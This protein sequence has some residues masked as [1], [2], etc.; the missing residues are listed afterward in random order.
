M[1]KSVRVLVFLAMWL[2]C[3]AVQAA[4]TYYCVAT[5][6]SDAVANP[7]TSWESP[8]LT[9]SNALA[10]SVAADVILVSNG[11]Y[12]LAQQI[13]VNKGVTI[14]GVNGPE[15]VV[16]DGNQ[17]TRCFYVTAVALLANMTLANG[18]TNGNGGG[19][20]LDNAGACVTNC[21]IRDNLTTNSGSATA[22]GGGVFISA[23][24]GILSNCFI[25]G[26]QATH[27]YYG[28]KNNGGGV[29]MLNGQVT[30][31]LIASNAVRNWDSAG[32]SQGGGI[33][34]FSGMASGCTISNNYS[35]NSG[36]GSYGSLSNCIIAENSCY[37][38]GGGS[39]LGSSPLGQRLVYCTIISNR[40]GY[41]GYGGGVYIDSAAGLLNCVVQGNRAY[42]VAGISA[43]SVTGIWNT[44]ICQN[45]ST[46][47]WG[48][49]SG[50]NIG[51]GSVGRPT[52]L[53]NCTIVS[54]YPGHGVCFNDASR[55]QNIT[56]CI[57]AYN[58]NTG[59][60]DIKFFGTTYTTNVFY[61][62]CCPT[63]VLPANQG[64]ITNAPMFKDFV[65]GNYRLATGSPCINAGANLAGMADTVD[66]DGHL[67]IDKFSGRIDIGAYEYL[68]HGTLFLMR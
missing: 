65:S 60:S 9:I 45:V 10:K 23:T 40:C 32:W 50:I 4:T 24:G 12:K 46:G 29:Y 33:Y 51:G 20:Y 63:T 35:S 1:K 7:G 11:T 43:S 5:N 2:G 3:M 19:L 48:Y 62:C 34:V 37:K 55:P 61:S 56:N 30:R 22:H 49:G 36:G 42:Y 59:V 27:K 47:D 57:V 25:I 38:S 39:T 44:L 26:N 67:R 21:I 6:G 41:Q 58:G 31:C 53:V 15:T 16:V 17:V 14:Q 8:L 64:N 68:L 18:Y 13:S 28:D 52:S 66:L 54:N